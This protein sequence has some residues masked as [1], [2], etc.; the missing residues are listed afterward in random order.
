MIF[1]INLCITYNISEE[2]D[3]QFTQTKHIHIR[4]YNIYYNIYTTC[5]TTKRNVNRLLYMERCSRFIIDYC[6]LAIYY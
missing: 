2:Y 1:P 4:K 6:I 5:I 3:I